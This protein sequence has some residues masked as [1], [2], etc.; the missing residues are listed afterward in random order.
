MKR[1]E[2]CAGRLS[3]ATNRFDPLGWRA[4]S[5]DALSKVL[6]TRMDEGFID[7]LCFLLYLLNI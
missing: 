3:A 4:Y 6:I 2:E 7:E 1:Q 5:H